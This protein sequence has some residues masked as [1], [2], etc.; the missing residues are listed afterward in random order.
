MEIGL[1]VSGEETRSAVAWLALAQ[2][3]LLETRLLSQTRE[4]KFWRFVIPFADNP[5]LL[6][7]KQYQS[8]SAWI[9]NNDI[10]DN[11]S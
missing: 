2:T 8:L 1:E 3:T 5:Q 4:N 10:C 7:S 9:S 6:E 11:D